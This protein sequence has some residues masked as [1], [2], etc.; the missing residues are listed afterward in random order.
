MADMIIFFVSGAFGLCAGI[1]GSLWVTLTFRVKDMHMWNPDYENEVKQ[2]KYV[3]WLI[4]LIAVPC[5]FVVL[6]YVILVSI[7]PLIHLLFF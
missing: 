4:N 3:E 6:S 2:L 1:I 5:A 7:P